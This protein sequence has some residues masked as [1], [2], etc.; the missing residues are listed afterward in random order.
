MSEKDRR[1]PLTDPE[2]WLKNAA[3]MRAFAALAASGENK[4]SLLKIAAEYEKLAQ[5]AA[6]RSTG[7]GR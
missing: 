2:H 6:R 5:R 1:S 7:D 3:E 4:E